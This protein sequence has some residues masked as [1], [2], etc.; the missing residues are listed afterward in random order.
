MPGPLTPG[1]P[2]V[3]LSG[4]VGAGKSTVCLRLAEAVRESGRGV[5]GI[6]SRPVYDALGR[7]MGIEAVDLWSGEARPLASLVRPLGPWHCGPHSFDPAAF[8]WARRA[9]E[10]ALALGPAVAIL[11]EVGPLELAQGKGFAPLVGPLL[12]APCPVVLVVRRACRADLEARLAG[13][14]LV[15]EVEETTRSSLPETIA[16]AL[17]ICLFPFRAVT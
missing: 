1:T 17:G 4:E 12:A 14:G 3:L 11:D 5:A 9:V 15:V 10:E 8:A 16:A 7:K 2:V 6:L 13:R